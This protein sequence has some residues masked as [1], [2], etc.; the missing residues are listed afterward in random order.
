[1]RQRKGRTLTD[2]TKTLTAVADTN[3]ADSHTTDPHT[4]NDGITRD[5]ITA[6]PLPAHRD[7]W[8][9][10]LLAHPNLLR[11]MA[12]EIGGP[13]HVMYPARVGH[14]IRAFRQAFATAGV[15]G[16]IYYGKKANKADC[17][18]AEC[19]AHGAGV[20]VSS[21]AE[22]HAALAGGVDGGDLMVTGPAKSDELLRLAVRARAVIAIDALSELDRLTALGGPARVL[23]RALPPGSA[24]RFGLRGDQLD[25]AVAQTDPQTIRLEGFSFHLSG[26]DYRPRAE[27]AAALLE[28]CREARGWGHPITTISIGGGFGVDY[29]PEAAWTAFRTRL[30]PHWFHGDWEPKDLYP[31]HFPQPGPRMLTRVLE[32]DGLAQRLRREGIGLAVEPGRALLDRAGSTV[33]GV[34]GV[35]DLVAHGHSYLMLTANGTSLSLS[36]QWFGSEFLPDPVLWPPGPGT[37]TP[38]AVGGA[39]CLE[40]D[41][42]SRRRIPL[43]RAA[44]SGDLL[45]YPNTAGYQ[46]DSNESAFHDLAIPPKVVLRDIPGD[47]YEWSV[48]SRIT[49][50]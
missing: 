31:Y 9:R 39:S 7:P 3:G 45:V 28:R 43:P 8:E 35:K 18:V 32:H 16:T 25:L 11:E 36:E 13:F 48:E 27:L 6:A 22:L 12:T 4:D 20:D 26:Y 42:I 41:M 5:D 10:R 17:V 37:V 40:D 14:N 49:E 38:T 44:R 33:F 19:A 50:R 24:S 1:M 30:S 23:L 21:T 46:M 15:V 34:Q 2:F 29:V 47:S